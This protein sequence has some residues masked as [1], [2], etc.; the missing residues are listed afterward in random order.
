VHLLAQ[1]KPKVMK[2]SEITAESRYNEKIFQ[3]V[4]YLLVAVMLAC[5][6]ATV[7][8]LL[9]HIFLRWQPWYLAGIS[10]LVALDTLYSYRRFKRLTLF[11]SEWL[12]AAGTQAI[13]L[14]VTL[15]AV[16]GISHGLE[17]FMAELTA[18]WFAFLLSF[19]SVEFMIGGGI[20]VLTWAVSLAFAGLLDEMGLDAELIRMD[21][22][23]A[24]PDELRPPRER[25]LG[26]VFSLGTTLVFL[27]ALMRLD[28][29]SAL[30]GTWD[31]T[32][33]DVPTLSNGGASTLLYFMFALALLSQTQ[34]ITLHTRWS[35]NRIPAN[36]AIA[37]RW[38]L[39]SV[40][41]LLILAAFASLL[42]T[43]YSLGLLASAGYVLNII[44]YLLFTLAQILLA[45]ILF[46]FSLPF[47][48]LGRESPVEQPTLIPPTQP[49]F[50]PPVV[51]AASAPLPWLEVAKSLLFW[52]FFIA[53]LLF[54]LVQYLRQHEDVI[55]ALRARPGL[56]WLGKLW[57]WLRGAWQAA[58]KGITEAVSAGLERIRPKRT[59]AQSFGGWVNLRKLG[60]RQRVFFFYQAFLRRSGESGLP[61]SLSQT[62]LEFASRL[63]SALP[64]AEPD[65]EA[66]TG[67][68]I[69]ARYTPRP[70]EPEKA[71]RAREVWEHLKKALRGKKVA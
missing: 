70:V 21:G 7:V 8:S 63:D 45:I 15:R 4:S 28:F 36:R 44:G 32:V 39:Y 26:L 46:L 2:A 35:I 19:F 55:N 17:V 24:A 14:V 71:S 13:I 34:F 66:L 51:D 62:P 6:A 22:G 61:R 9:T 54:A 16:I 67:A 40:I 58:Q 18:G 25:M 31:A 37:G 53:V 43:S 52:G 50:L 10:F 47:L 41:F 65:I 23:L 68:F 42:P 57:D 64:E 27:T 56:G 29:R 3:L 11:S 12:A 69:E 48:L 20:C 33:L 30:T 49:E 5:A 59:L 1:R 60:P 38:A